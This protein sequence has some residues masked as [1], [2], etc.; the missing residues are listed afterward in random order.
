MASRCPACSARFVADDASCQQ[1]FDELLAL[2]FTDPAY[3]AVHHLTVTAFML[4]HN[5]YSHHGWLAARAL[6][7]ELVQDGFDPA[8]ARRRHQKGS[9]SITRGSRF[10]RFGEI[11]WTRT[12]ADVRTDDPAS[13]RQDVE[14]WARAVVADSDPVARMA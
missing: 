6:L 2:E 13:Y 10:P 7:A 11:R 3:F 12:I 8:E 14:T 1:R 9:S 4:Q 5:R